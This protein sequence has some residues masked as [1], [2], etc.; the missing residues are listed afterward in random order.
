VVGAVVAGSV[1]VTPSLTAVADDNDPAPAEWP[2]V[3][4]SDSGGDSADPATVSWPRVAKSGSGG[5]GADP[6][7]LDWPKVAQL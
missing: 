3:A 7:P 4:K 5:D 6:E 2:K 1:L